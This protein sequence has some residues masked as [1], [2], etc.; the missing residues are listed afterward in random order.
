MQGW[1]LKSMRL[2]AL[3]VAIEAFKKHQCLPECL[4]GAKKKHFDFS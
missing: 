1:E 2:N 4:P 3:E